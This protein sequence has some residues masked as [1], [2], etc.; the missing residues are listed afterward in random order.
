MKPVRGA[1]GGVIWAFHGT[2]GTTSRSW[3]PVQAGWLGAADGVIVLGH[4]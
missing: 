1:S 3:V 4:D 2:P